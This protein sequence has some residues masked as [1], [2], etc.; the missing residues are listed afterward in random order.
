LESGKAYLSYLRFGAAG[1]VKRL[2]QC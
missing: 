2:Q 1:E